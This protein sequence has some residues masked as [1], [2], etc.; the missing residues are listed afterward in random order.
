MGTQPDV[1]G[2]DD[3]AAAGRWIALGLAAVFGAQNMAEVVPAGAGPAQRY[4]G[5]GKLSPSAT[6]DR[7]ASTATHASPD[8]LTCACGA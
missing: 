8:R 1:T 6:K 3:K 2:P 7:T 4:R 5:I